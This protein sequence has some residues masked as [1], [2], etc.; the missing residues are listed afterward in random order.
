MKNRA[1]DKCVTLLVYQIETPEEKGTENIIEETMK[2]S[3]S[4]LLLNINLY[5][6][7]PQQTP[8]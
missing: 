1:L 3:L 5:L 4:S 8:K 2:Y 6:L 7:I